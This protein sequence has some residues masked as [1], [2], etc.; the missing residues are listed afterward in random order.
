[1]NIHRTTPRTLSRRPVVK[2]AI[3]LTVS[4][5]V[6]TQW[7]K[8]VV[9]SIVSLAHAQTSN[10]AFFQIS[11]L[12]V[13]NRG[14]DGDVLSGIEVIGC[15]TSGAFFSVVVILNSVS[16]TVLQSTDSENL[17]IPENTLLPISE[18]DSVTV[19]Y[20]V[21]DV[22]L[23]KTLTGASLLGHLNCA[24]NNGP[25]VAISIFCGPRGRD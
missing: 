13:E 5:S 10:P 15:S 22:H 21:N 3:F 25:C 9:Q 23:S 24:I 14:A 19:T 8:P 6:A 2:T 17:V 1:M 16:I 18:I 4:T 12:L 11:R 20:S 7:S